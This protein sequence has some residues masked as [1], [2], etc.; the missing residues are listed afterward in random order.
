MIVALEF[1]TMSIPRIRILPIV[2][3]YVDYN[4]L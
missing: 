2:I 1:K 3:I 4:V